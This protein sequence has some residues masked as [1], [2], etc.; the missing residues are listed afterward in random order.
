MIIP[1]S[2]DTPL[3]HW[4]IVTGSVIAIN[5]IAFFTITIGVLSGSLS[6]EDIQWLML[7]PD[8]INPLQWITSLFIHAHIAHLISNMFFLFVFGLIVEGKAGSLRFSAIFFGVGIAVAAITQVGLYVT[9]SEI[10]GV[11]ASAAIAGLMMVA[12][13]FAPENEVYWLLFVWRI[14]TPI[15]VFSMYF[16]ALDVLGVAISGFEV[17][18]ATGHVLGATL[19]F[20]AGAYLLRTD[21]VD[22]EGWD[23][24]SR[25]DWLKQYPILYSDKQRQRDKTRTV[26]DF[27][28]VTSALALEG[29]D[30]ENAV[31]YGSTTIPEVA[32]SYQEDRKK[33]QEKR[34][35]QRGKQQR[36]YK[37][38]HQTV[39]EQLTLKCQADPEFNRMA[40][41]FRES[42]K[43]GNMIEAQRQFRALDS[44]KLI[45]GIAEQTLIAFAKQLGKANQWTDAIRPLMVLI[46]KQG[47]MMDEGR[48]TLAQIQAKV[49]K[50]SDLAIKTLEQIESPPPPSEPN[51][52]VVVPEVIRRRD[53]LLCKFKQTV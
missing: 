36:K 21:Q 6:F 13:L 8:Q 45:H 50:R 23:A 27:D 11:G 15:A 20:L 41:V 31:R 2:T 17:T 48:I 37:R 44:A 7:M 18:A 40:F 39:A 46:E 9:G 30:V 52:P 22:C 26:D 34:K 47:P 16:I 4:P 5:V 51:Q 28:P 12:L 24:V 53:E 38:V 29:G 3:Y 32:K 35:L 25:N 33:R 42:L 43:A 10:P 1:Y 14:D 19:G 49:M